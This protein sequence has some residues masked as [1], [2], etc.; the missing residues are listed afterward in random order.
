MTSTGSLLIPVAIALF[1]PLACPG[2]QP[3]QTLLDE[4]YGQMYNSD[5]AAAH[6][7]FSEWEK[8]HPKDPMGAVSDAAAYLFSELDRLHVLK[9][10]FFT[11]DAGFVRRE[12]SLSADPAVKR[13][14][15][16]ALQRARLEASAVLARSPDDE[17]AL[18]ATVLTHGLRADFLSFIEKRNLPALSEA[19]QARRIAQRLLALHPECYD[20]Y[21]AI[22]VENYLLSLRALPLRWLLRLGGAQTSKQTGV[23]RLRMTAEK[24]RY[25][26]PF[27]RLLLA[28]AALRDSKTAE[29]R[30]QLAWLAARFPQNVLYR[31]ELKKLK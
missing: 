27:A 15:E 29:A 6:R 24:G 13:F 18:L 23:E 8:L 28:V 25:L 26:G 17:N 31:D 2:Y 3:E 19:K 10:E 30:R 21:L 12:H 4:G 1:I 7:S 9:S 20:A 16:Q 14:F 5:F 11:D 22:G